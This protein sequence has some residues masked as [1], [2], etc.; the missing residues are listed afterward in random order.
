[1]IGQE[2]GGGARSWGDRERGPRREEGEEAILKEEEHARGKRREAMAKI[3][4]NVAN[5]VKSSPDGAQ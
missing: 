4:E 5:W 2:K 1:M 3:Q